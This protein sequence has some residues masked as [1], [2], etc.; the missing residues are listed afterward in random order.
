M[1]TIDEEEYLEHY[2][3]PRRSGRYPWG[4]SG[5]GDD[6]EDTI[7]RN[8]S[9]LDYIAELKKKGLSDGEIAKG[10]DL[11]STEYRARRTIANAEQK[12]AK[13]SMAQ[14][15][16]DKG[17]SYKA[18]AE[19]MD[20]AGESSARALL[21][22]GVKEKADALFATSDM[23]KK[24][25]EEKG[26]IDV[27]DGVETYLDISKE[28]LK[29]AVEVLKERFGF[30]VHTVP[31]PQISTG[32]DTRR[33]VL[34]P[35][36][37]T[38]KDVF[39]NRDKIRLITESSDDGGHTYT[40]IKD[41]LPVSPNRVDVVYG[42]DGGELQDGVIYVREGT[43]DLSLGNSR[44]AQVRIKVGEGHYLKGMA[45]YKDDLPPGTDLLF[46][47]NKDDSGNKLDALKKI[48]DDPELPFGSV[49][50]Q[51]HEKPGDRESEVIS[52]MNIV[53]EQGDW[54]TWS[55]T[56]SSQVLSKQEPKLAREQL[57]LTYDLR[58]AEYDEIM[59]LTNP[60]IKKKLLEKFAD[61]AD[62]KA[63]HLDAAK[64]PR[65]AWKAIL[66]VNSLSDTEVYA[67]GFRDGEPVAL[68]RYPHGGTFEIP[69]LKVNNKH[70]ESKR[71]LGD[72][73]DAIGI[74]ANTAQRLSGA[75]FDGDTVLIIPNRSGKIKDAPALEGLKDFTPTREYPPYDGM[76]TMDGGVYNAATKE[77]DYGGKKP[78]NRTKGIEMGKISNLITDMTIKGAPH[79]KIARAV[80]HSM[81][82][83]DAEKHSLNYRESA[84]VNG[85]SALKKEY[86]GKASAG[87]ATLISRAGAKIRIPERKPRPHS[88]GGPV[89]K[90]TGRKEFV[91][92]GRM[93]TD[94]KTG[95]KVPR[96]E[97]VKRLDITDDAYTLVSEP[98]GTQIEKI[99]ADHSNKLK[100]LANKARLDAMREPNLKY[101]QSANKVYAKE[102]ASL[103]AKVTLAKSN[104]P[105]ERQANAIAEANIR[106][107]KQANPNLDGDSLKK[108]SF[109]ELE[110]ARIRMGAKKQIIEEITPKEWDAIQ[111]GAVSNNMLN[112]VLDNTDVEA[113]RKL[114]TP[115]TS[116][117]MPTAKINR[118]QS[119]LS[120]GYTRSEVADQLGVSV[121]TLDKAIKGEGAYA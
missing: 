4:S 10:L 3:T 102:V 49:V 76:K 85:I 28:R 119:M 90:T 22:P 63:V 84:R 25:V 121:T 114:A 41:P 101:N 38:Q 36:G 23:L 92:S 75:D 9:F 80:K 6:G 54:A 72:A 110:K 67:P 46:H 83:I 40:P 97:T 60:T 31:Q 120:S 96:K 16:R 77:V 51:I 14:R 37:T 18:I 44:Y 19:R 1:V 113:V 74:N 78:S 58:K 98:S 62:S 21:A 27:G 61:S 65:Q 91:P 47:T 95:E 82:V 24:Q 26:Y 68:I 57:N 53:H 12:Q 88:E 35:P 20:L 105:L 7:Q 15:L 87:A 100:G 48:S 29:S 8:M 108:I 17:W 33:K 89:D 86:Q 52:A 56:I 50:R 116:L 111:A 103:K 104:R 71:L 13:I 11:S 70:P 5:W 69:M 64:L 39:L 59:E 79:S 30:T 2:G 45:M 115:R 81:V 43:K 66:P 107:K 117:S 109:E 94:K 99:Y 73:E 118:A 32:K 55:K 42:P 112:D 106:A 93:R 34:A